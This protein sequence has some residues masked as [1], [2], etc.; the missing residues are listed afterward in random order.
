MPLN[1]AAIPFKP[2][3]THSRDCDGECVFDTRE[4]TFTCMG[5]PLQVEGHVDGFPF[6]FRARHGKWRIEIGQSG[7]G[8]VIAH[9]DT[10]DFAPG[11]AVDLI[12]TEMARWL[13]TV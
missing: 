7:G 5:C 4:F 3:C 6:C 2:A 10:D 1:P 9:G 11:Q 8:V 13:W 12:E